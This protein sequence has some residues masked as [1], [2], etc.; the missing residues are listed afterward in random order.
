MLFTHQVFHVPPPDEE[1]RRSTEMFQPGA[2][3]RRASRLKPPLGGEADGELGGLALPVSD[4]EVGV[5]EVLE[6]V[7]SACTCSP[8]GTVAGG[9]AGQ[10]RECHPLSEQT[11]QCQQVNRVWVKAHAAP[12]VQ[13]LELC[14]WNFSSPRLVRPR[15]GAAI[16]REPDGPQA[17]R[18]LSHLSEGGAWSGTGL[19][20]FAPPLPTCLSHST[21]CLLWP[22]SRL[23]ECVQWGIWGVCNCPLLAWRS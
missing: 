12:G 6:A 16:D 1:N 7:L 17:G 5:G 11:A 20:C 4:C 13:V 21:R 9:G 22:H 14:P 2:C 23:L 3:G 8:T 19:T 15:G 10:F 18:G